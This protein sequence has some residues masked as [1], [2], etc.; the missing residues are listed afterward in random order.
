MFDLINS[1]ERHLNRKI[2]T[3]LIVNNVINHIKNFI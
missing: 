3:I 2:S 1:I